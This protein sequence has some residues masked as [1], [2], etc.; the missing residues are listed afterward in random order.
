MTGTD[1]AR[2]LLDLVGGPANVEQVTRC[3]VRLRFVLRDP[4]L[5]DDD[6]LAA[7]DGVLLVVRQGGQLQLAL[8]VPL[9]EVHRDVRALLTA[10]R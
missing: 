4:D 3:M 10:A 8:A 5:A 7:L 6:A 2:R 9:T 1:L